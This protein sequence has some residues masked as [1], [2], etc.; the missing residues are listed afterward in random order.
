MVMGRTMAVTILTLMLVR[1]STLAV[2]VTDEQRIK[3]GDGSTAAIVV[4]C[5]TCGAD[6]K[7]AGKDTCVAGTSE[8]F[9]GGE[10]CGD[11]LMGSNFGFRAAHAFDLQFIGHLTDTSGKPLN[12][13]FVKIVEPNGW[14]FTTRTGTDGLFRIMIGATLARAGNPPVNKDLGT[15]A[16]RPKSGKEGAFV[17]YILPEQFKPC[18]PA[19]AKKKK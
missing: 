18:E 16:A 12:N 15:F 3:N 17:F 1:S 8:G 14:V 11:C 13:Q 19:K 5:N 2:T 7:S 6:K 10:P 4:T 9:L